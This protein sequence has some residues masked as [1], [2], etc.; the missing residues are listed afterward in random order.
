[1]KK[2]LLLIF[3]LQILHILSKYTYESIYEL[4][5]KFYIFKIRDFSSY[6][7]YKYIP[8]C[9]EDNNSIKNIYLQLI[10]SNYLEFYKYEN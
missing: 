6:K 3:I 10:S 2:N 7:I 9:K 4:I 5:N 8:L 1:M